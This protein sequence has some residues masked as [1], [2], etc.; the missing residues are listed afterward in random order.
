MEESW[1]EQELAEQN[2]LCQEIEKWLESES[3]PYKSDVGF[4]EFPRPGFSPEEF[5]KLIAKAEA[6]FKEL[7]LGESKAYYDVFETTIIVDFPEQ[8]KW[9]ETFY[10]GDGAERRM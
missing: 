1:D 3:I 10:G 7:K 6:K 2:R 5:K 8:T 4:I 9:F